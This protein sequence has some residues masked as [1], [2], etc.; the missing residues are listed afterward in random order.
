M[1]ELRCKGT[2][3][4]KPCNRKLAEINNE[5]NHLPNT[6]EIICPKCGKLNKI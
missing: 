1:K 4:G 6:V 2:Y 5:A 3:K